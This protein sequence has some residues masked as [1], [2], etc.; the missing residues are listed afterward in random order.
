MCAEIIIHQRDAVDEH[1]LLWHT[2]LSQILSPCKFT[3]A[4]RSSTV[5]LVSI[6]GVSAASK[7]CK[8]CNDYCFMNNWVVIIAILP[9]A[10]LNH[11]S[12]DCLF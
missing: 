1:V 6:I 7:L 3:V 4:F 12:C 9:A 2:L 8:R 11:H 10:S 5:A